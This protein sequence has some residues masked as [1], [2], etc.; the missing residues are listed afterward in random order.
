MA[1]IMDYAYGSVCSKLLLV[2]KTIFLPKKILE[3][4]ALQSFLL[5]FS[6][7]N[8]IC[9]TVLKKIFVI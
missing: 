1:D 3:A 9:V 4:F 6:A 7:K 8:I 5:F 2:T